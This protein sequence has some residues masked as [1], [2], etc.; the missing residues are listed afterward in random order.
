[1]QGFNNK[2]GISRGIYADTDLFDISVNN[3]SVSINSQVFKLIEGMQ[4]LIMFVSAKC[5]CEYMIVCT[6][7][8]SSNYSLLD[9]G[10]DLSTETEW[11]W[12]PKI[13]TS[14]QH[15]ISVSQNSLSF[16]NGLPW[17]SVRHAEQIQWHQFQQ[18][19]SYKSSIWEYT[20]LEM[21]FYC[22]TVQCT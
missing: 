13:E 4:L 22:T 9:R 5:N 8:Q 7:Q 19:P 21:R 16:S 2:L 6:T 11:N 14:W 15:S 12:H 18:A 17:Q 20:Y 10:A 3:V 1:M